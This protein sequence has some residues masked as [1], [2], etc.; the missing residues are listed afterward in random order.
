[1]VARERI[2]QRWDGREFVDRDD[3]EEDDDEDC[4]WDL[5]VASAK[6]ELSVIR[7]RAYAI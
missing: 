5:G 6:D 2:V 1:M 7:A 3:E 4:W